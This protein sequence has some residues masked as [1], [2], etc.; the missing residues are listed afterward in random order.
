MIH[1]ERCAGNFWWRRYVQYS[2]TFGGTAVVCPGKSGANY[3]ASEVAKSVRENKEMCTE[4]VERP[5][6]QVACLCFQE[7][8]ETNPD[9]TIRELLG[10]PEDEPVPASWNTKQEIS[11]ELRL[12]SASVVSYSYEATKAALIRAAM[13]IETLPEFPKPS[14][15]AGLVAEH[16]ESARDEK[17]PV[18]LDSASAAARE[19][20]IRVSEVM[21]SLFPGGCSS[22]HNKDLLFDLVNLAAVCQRI[23]EDMGWYQAD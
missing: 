13:A 4:I 19:L 18:K 10:L 16:I 17:K 1:D 20:S 6:L 21:K 14:T 5:D 8:R 22:M 15:F 3:Q 11:S 9:L 7:H 12:M 2:R 23:A